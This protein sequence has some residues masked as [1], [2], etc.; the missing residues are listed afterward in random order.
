M[1]TLEEA[2]E[3]M[4]NKG[5][6]HTATNGDKTLLFFLKKMPDGK[7]HLH[8]TLFLTKQ[9]VDLDTTSILDLGISLY[10]ESILMD[11]MNF[12]SFEERLYNYTYLCVYGKQSSNSVEECIQPTGLSNPT[13][14]ET[15]EG[16]QSKTSDRIGGD[17]KGE[18]KPKKPTI[19]E[20]KKTFWEE[21]KGVAKQKGYPKELAIE[22]YTYWTED[23]KSKTKF[24]KEAENY[25]DIPKR[26]GTWIKNNKLWS[27]QTFIEQKAEKQNE[28][29]K[30][31]KKILN[32]KELF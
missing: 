12:E 10:C 2:I 8:A 22:F 31:P 1:Y 20:R 32:H 24:R 13:I 15:K 18:G 9:T 5:Y 26:F 17:V 7:I 4:N 27:K 21:V 25:F 6:K 3:W 29:L 16:K 30:N 14:G 11:K 19:D 23:N 28:E